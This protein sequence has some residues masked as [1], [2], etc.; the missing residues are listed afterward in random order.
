[1]IKTSIFSC[2]LVLDMDVAKN[3][4]KRSKTEELSLR[5]FDIN[6]KLKVIF[7]IL[8]KKFI[9]TTPFRTSII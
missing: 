3:Q 5:Q 9:K 4:V 1:M 8:L 7:S 2:H 6:Y